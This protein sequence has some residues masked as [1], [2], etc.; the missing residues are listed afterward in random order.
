MKSHYVY[1]LQYYKEQSWDIGETSDLRKRIKQ[2]Q[3]C[4]VAST[5][6]RGPFRIVLYEYF[7]NNK[8][9]KARERFLKSGFGREQMKKALQYTQ[10]ER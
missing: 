6:Y 1:I 9:A 3:S 2:H 10:L 8:D 7:F 4:Q 5:R